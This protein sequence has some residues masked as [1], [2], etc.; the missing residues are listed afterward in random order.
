MLK[1]SSQSI[2]LKQNNPLFRL[3][4]I[5][6][7]QRLENVYKKNLLRHPADVRAALVCFLALEKSYK[8]LSIYLK[9]H[10]K[11]RQ[12]PAELTH[13]LNSY[14]GV[15]TGIHQDLLNTL[16]LYID[17]WLNHDSSL[18]MSKQ[19]RTR[20]VLRRIRKKADLLWESYRKDGFLRGP[21]S[22]DEIRRL[23]YLYGKYHQ[24]DIS[25]KHKEDYNQWLT[26]GLFRMLK[27]NFK[28]SHYRLRHLFRTELYAYVTAS[29][30]EIGKT[31]ESRK[32]HKG[33][34][35][36]LRELIRDCLYGYAPAVAFPREQ[37]DEPGIRPRILTD[38]AR[39]EKKIRLRNFIKVLAVLI[40][41]FMTAGVMRQTGFDQVFIRSLKFAARDITSITWMFTKRNDKSGFFEKEMLNLDMTVSK[42][43]FKNNLRDFIYGDLY[44]QDDKYQIF[45]QRI[46]RDYLILLAKKEIDIGLENEVY[47]AG[48]LLNPDVVE[49]LERLTF[50]Y[51]RNVI[52]ETELRNQILKLRRIFVAHD[53][54]PFMFL[55]VY[56]NT[57]YIFLFNEKIL[58]TMDLSEEDVQSLGVD[59]F[60]FDEVEKRRLKAYL[61]MGDHYPFAGKA[62]FF[63][64]EFAVVFISLSTKP[65]WT[66]WH[67]LGHVVD[68]MKYTY[69]GIM[70][71]DNIEVFSVLFPLIFTKDAKDYLNKYLMPTIRSKDAKDYYVQSA[72]GILNGAIS[73]FNEKRNTDV[74]LIT[75]RFEDK[76]IDWVET[77]LNS[78]TDDQLNQLARV[79]YTYPDRFLATAEKARYHTV[80][81]N[82]EEII[83]GIHSSPQKEVVEIQPIGSLFSKSKGPRFI[84][85]GQG[86]QDDSAALRRAALIR[87]VIVFVLFE[88]LAI[89]IHLVATPFR[90]LKFRGRQP[91]KMIDRMFKAQPPSGAD[92]KNH[93]L[94]AHELLYSIYDSSYDKG[95]IF[96]KKIDLFRLTSTNRERF[97]FHAGLSLAPTIPQR[98]VIKNEF[99]LLLFYLPFLGPY[100]ARLRWIF[101][102]QRDFQQREKFNLKIRNIILKASSRTPMHALSNQLDQTMRQFE[103]PDGGADKDH[104]IDFAQI[105]TWVL[106]YIDKVYGHVRL[107][108]EG[109][110]MDLSRLNKAMDRGSEF[111]R[112]DTYIPGDD[113]RQID[114]NVT[115]R[116]TMQQAMV[117]K[118][119]HDEEVQVAFLFD[120]TTLDTVV[121]QKKWAADLAKSIRAVGENNHLKTIILLYPDGQYVIRQ[122]K[123]HSKLHSKRLAS[124]VLSM[125]KQQ[126]EKSGHRLNAAR[127][128]GLT[129]YSQE[130]NQRY[131]KQLNWL[132]FD[133]MDQQTTLGH[134]KI[135]NHTIFMIGVKPQKKKL[136]SHVLNRKNK[137]VFW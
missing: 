50:Y 86:P 83:Y 44:K 2:I 65:E 79:M 38:F 81:T 128:K 18:E 116:N 13:T 111:D 25:V 34:L 70:V 23:T 15:L 127:Y 58:G 113:I 101:P 129:F 120:M 21:E 89:L 103:I 30:S 131:R 4:I 88:L 94:T 22:S 64:G 91:L 115:A 61:M 41:L 1:V 132:S 36:A 31:D 93:F 102:W 104:D 47:R 134:L 137:P 66:G 119:V 130:E 57:P 107:N 17:S 85:D 39:L 8:R 62:G 16:Y 7:V 72:K 32:E 43:A 106:A 76:S 12:Y 37:D 105:E 98:S 5:R 63:E 84:R 73:Y 40:V 11:S 52:L 117:R 133:F 135:R 24:Q 100:L 27:R 54:Y 20:R 19:F 28:N 87:A 112:L 45:A 75:N 29:A 78:L 82:T 60:W 71:P 77:R 14:L 80:L 118:R 51:S 33:I 95:E 126:W 10:V 67:E 109:R 74:P 9:R 122:V 92:N 46:L 48:F 114:W 136:I 90:L 68:Y 108:Y 124:K 99:H 110:W 49:P 6:K 42:D 123:L 53:I 121:N 26:E 56:E 96:Q 59:T 3:S 55:V 69:A 97:L 35:S 125:V